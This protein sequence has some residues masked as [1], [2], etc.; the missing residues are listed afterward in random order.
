MTGQRKLAIDWEQAREGLARATR[1][2]T[3]HRFEADRIEAAYHERATLLARPQAATARVEDR[4]LLTFRLGSDAYAAPVS[5]VDRII[6]HPVCTPLPDSNA[7]W[8]GVLVFDG[9]VLPVLHLGRAL[10][11]PEPER[12]D[13]AHALKL[14]SIGV[15]CCLLVGEILEIRSVPAAGLRPFSGDIRWVEGAAPGDALVLD[16]ESLVAQELSK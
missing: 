10:G 2:L 8:A 3:D 9:I 6:P 15:D 16:V 11:L 13:G 1:S 4:R 7:K 14:H 12:P 5:A